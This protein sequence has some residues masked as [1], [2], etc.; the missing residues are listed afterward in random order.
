MSSDRPVIRLVIGGM[1]AAVAWSS[2]G[3]VIARQ[4]QLSLL[5]LIP[6]TVALYATFSGAVAWHSRW[7]L[8]VLTAAAMAAVDMSV[9]TP[10]SWITG[11]GVPPD[12][13]TLEY[14]KNMAWGAATL[15]ALGGFIGAPVGAYM[16]SRKLRS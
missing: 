1:L 3:L 4:F 8:G 5:Y 9:G 16:R 11:A 2:I 14:F 15:A 7:D 10:V 6:V 12:T 13:I